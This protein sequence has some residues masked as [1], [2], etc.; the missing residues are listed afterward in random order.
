[1]IFT[2]G[3]ATRSV[4]E[5]IALLRQ[6]SIDLLVDVRSMPRSRT[7]PQFNAEALPRPLTAAGI[8]YRHLA[9]LGGLRG[10]RK[11]GTPSPNALRR[12]DAFR[13]YA[14]TQAFRVGLDELVALARDAR[15]AVMCAEA[16]WWRCHR[17]II[18]P[19]AEGD[20]LIEN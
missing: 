19:Q 4:A 2:I 18:A 15:C 8:R 5:F 14:A 1:M 7:N 16:L 11:K 12:N 13:N 17:R 9:A 3:H 20:A 10:L 6:I